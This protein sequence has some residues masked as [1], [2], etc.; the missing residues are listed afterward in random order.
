MEGIT[1]PNSYAVVPA[2]ALN[3]S[4]AAVAQRLCESF[5]GNLE[6]G[7]LQEKQWL[8]NAFELIVEV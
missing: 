2:V 3:Q 1:L 6:H 7:K 5:S 4:K 8:K